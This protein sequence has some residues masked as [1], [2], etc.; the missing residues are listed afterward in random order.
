MIVLAAVRIAMRRTL[1]SKVDPTPETPQSNKDYAGITVL[2][3]V[4]NTPWARLPHPVVSVQRLSGGNRRKFDIR[5][6]V[7]LD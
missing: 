6:S 2:N 3:T 4:L 7:A 5:A 1:I